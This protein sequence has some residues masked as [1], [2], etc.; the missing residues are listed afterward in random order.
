M[1]FEA[2]LGLLDQQAEVSKEAQSLSKMVCTNQEIFWN[3]LK[4]SDRADEEGPFSW[5]MV[6]HEDIKVTMYS[7]DIIDSIIKTPA[8]PAG[9][10]E[11]ALRFN[12]VERF[13]MEGGF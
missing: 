5:D 2:L 3:I 10:R 13:L 1:T 4:L 8:A 9:S 6:F 7:L 11:S 12:W